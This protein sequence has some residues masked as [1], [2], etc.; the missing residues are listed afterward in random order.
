MMLRIA[1]SPLFRSATPARHTPRAGLALAALGLLALG[2]GCSKREGEYYETTPPK[3]ETPVE[4]ATDA[5]LPP[6]HPPLAPAASELPEGH[7]PLDAM[8]P[9]AGGMDMSSQTLSPDMIGRGDTPIWALPEG[10]EEVAPGPMRRAT[11]R[12]GESGLELAV[13]SFPGDVGGL[14]ANVNRWR[15]QLGLP[16]VP[17]SA[18]APFVTELTVDEKTLLV[19]D[20]LGPPPADGGPNQRL[21]ATVA[22]DAGN[23]WFFKMTG[24]ASAVEAHKADYLAFIESLRFPDSASGPAL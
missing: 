4:T 22:M 5:P 13:T 19:I 11:F 20:L 17:E 18:M 2:T 21:L 9:A 24:A 1:I 14:A 23:S 16:P 7:P 6:G 8:P 3:T 12:L 10:W 15:Q